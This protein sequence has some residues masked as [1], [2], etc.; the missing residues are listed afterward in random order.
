[1]TTLTK[2]E[3]CGCLDELS[4][5]R[6]ALI[7][8]HEKFIYIPGSNEGVLVEVTFSKD[9][10]GD[11]ITGVKVSGLNANTPSNNCVEN[12]IN[13]LSPQTVELYANVKYRAEKWYTDG[14]E[15]P[16]QN[17]MSDV[18]RDITNK[19]RCKK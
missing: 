5:K 6:K 15:F 1:M 19:Y 16:T 2:G 3:L 18:I 11:K 14:T 17:T 7:K 9:G 4:S 8:G 13:K 12:D 10:Y